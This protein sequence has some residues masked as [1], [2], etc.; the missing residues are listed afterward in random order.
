MFAISVTINDIFAIGRDLTF[1][2]VKVK[3]KYDNQ[4]HV[5]DFLYDRNINICPL[6]HHLR[7]IRNQNVHDLDLDL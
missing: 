5:H 1:R 2:M 3:C 4:K 7:D 6:W